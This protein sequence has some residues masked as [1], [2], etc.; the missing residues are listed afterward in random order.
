MI[1][2][3]AVSEERGVPAWSVRLAADL[4]AYD[5]AARNL[6]GEL[7]EEQ[8]NWQPAPD[9]WSVGQCIEHL[10]ITNEAY[11]PAISVAVREQPD[12]PVEQ[13]TPGWFGLWFIRSFIESSPVAKR[14]P[15]PTK[16]RPTAHVGA[17]VLARFLAGNESCRELM[18]RVRAKN[19]NRIRFWNPLIPGIRFTVGTG[20][21]IIV[22]HE[23]RHLLQAERVLH[24]PNFP[25]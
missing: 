10:C 8:L 21:E 1:R 22:G 18:T 15:A 19:V 23:R 20:L 12:S 16:I 3:M 24:S 14:A 5:Q 11:L 17:S 2:A 7:T 4:D 6:V 25:R 9:S 13:I